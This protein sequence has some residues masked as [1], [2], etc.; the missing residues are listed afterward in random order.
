MLARLKHLTV[1]SVP[2]CWRDAFTQTGVHE[3]AIT[4]RVEVDE[5]FDLR[6][7][8]LAELPPPVEGNKEGDESVSAVGR[9]A[10]TS[11]CHCL[12]TLPV[13]KQTLR[14]LQVVEQ[15]SVPMGNDGSTLSDEE[16]SG[17]LPPST[18]GR[19]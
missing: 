10:E 2:K 15:G 1:E 4:G 6:T 7:D 11:Q 3:F 16:R 8:H 17:T 12:R 18:I 19:W 9:V 13:T 14:P 5:G